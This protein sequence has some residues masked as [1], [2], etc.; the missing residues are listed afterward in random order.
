MKVKALR[1][2]VQKLEQVSSPRSA[3]SIWYGSVD[4]WVNEYIIPDV[5]AGKLC[6]RDM[7]DV[8]AAIRSWGDD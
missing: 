8:V 6:P 2:R 3:I 4:I 7:V 5:A 1:K